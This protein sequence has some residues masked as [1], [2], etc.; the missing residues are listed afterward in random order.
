MEG[1]SI[2]AVTLNPEIDSTFEC[3]MDA[4]PSELLTFKWSQN[5][6]TQL[7]T[8]RSFTLAAGNSG[9]TTVVCTGSVAPSVSKYTIV[10]S[11][12]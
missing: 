2:R 7:E 11:L 12:Q 6:D 10:M 9:I 1:E 4:S 3:I 8:G 5:G